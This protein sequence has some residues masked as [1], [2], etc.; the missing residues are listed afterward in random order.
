MWGGQ[1]YGIIK[2]NMNQNECVVDFS[3]HKQIR[4]W[5][6]KFFQCFLWIVFFLNDFKKHNVTCTYVNG[7]NSNSLLT[8]NHKR[9][10]FFI[11]SRWVVSF[12]DVLSIICSVYFIEQQKHCFL[13]WT[14]LISVSDPLYIWVWC[15]WCCTANIH[16][17]SLIVT[18]WYWGDA[19][20]WS[21]CNRIIWMINN[22]RGVFYIKKKYLWMFSWVTVIQMD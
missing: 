14:V 11:I 22:K 6:F 1:H 12:T 8:I 15:P 17:G 19:Y 2:N 5:N 7:N 3:S 21:F 16:W 13:P 10:V 18:C 9:P 4:L 20:L